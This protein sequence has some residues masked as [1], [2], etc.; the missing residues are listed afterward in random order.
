MSKKKSKQGAKSQLNPSTSQE[1]DGD[2]N[3]DGSEQ[4]Y[5]V[6]KIINK[7]YFHKFK[8]WRY[9]VLWKN[10]SLKDATWEPI[11]HL[12]GVINEVKRFER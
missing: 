4:L 7:K 11:E 9:L 1:G 3:A 2:Q 5:I 6:D 10:Y 8:Q 12:E